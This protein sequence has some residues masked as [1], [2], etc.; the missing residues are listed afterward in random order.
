MT[1]PLVI[2]FDCKGEIPDRAVPRLR[3]ARRLAFGDQKVRL[4]QG[5]NGLGFGVPAPTPTIPFSSVI[6]FPK[7]QH[8]ISAAMKRHVGIFP[9]IPERTLFLDIE[10]HNAGREYE[11]PRNEFV[12]LGQ[13]AWGWDGGIVLTSDVD[14]ILD[15]IEAADLVIAHNGHT[16]DFSV[17][18]GDRAL[19]LTFEGRLF[20]TFVH[21]NMVFPPP[22]T[23][24]NRAGRKLIDTD[25]PKGAM[26][27]LGLDNL[28]FQLR[29]EGKIGSLADI[30][31]RYN[32]EG[33]SRADLDFGLIPL[34]DPEFREYAEQD[35]V[36]LRGVA[37]ELLNARPISEYDRR[38]Q[39]KAAINGQMSRNGIR[40]D[41]DAAKARVNEIE[42]RK[43]ELLAKLNEQYGFPIE[44]KMP[45]R[46]KAGKEAIFK[47][48]ADHGITKQTR[49]NWPLTDTGNLSLSGPALK[50]IT[51]GTDA[52]EL[53]T[54]LGILAGQRPLAQ[55]ALDYVRGDGRVHPSI[56]AVQRSGRC[57]VT[58]PG[59]T[60]WSARGPGAVEKQYFIPTEGHKMLEFDLSN[61]DQRIIAALSGDTAYA[62]RFDEGV[63]GHEINGRLMFG[64]KYDTDPA[65]YRNLAKA[66]GHALTYG[67]GAKRLAA[68]S[69]LDVETMYRFVDNFYDKYPLV[70][71]WTAK[72]RAQGE[73]YDQVT[74]A[75]GRD[76]IIDRY[77][78][79]ERGEWS[80]KAWTQAPALHGQSGTTEVCYDGLIRMYH[81][82]RRLLNWVICPIHDAILMDVPEDETEYVRKA[83]KECLETTIN[84]VHFPVSSGPDG[85]N[86]FAA[87][88]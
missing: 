67:A 65:Y 54:D 83:V 49:P 42:T 74:N 28:A 19:D 23:Y 14:E 34:D 6:R 35:I 39:V 5:P 12:R 2:E 36:A 61:A 59:M 45:W 9:D 66:P 62:A 44:G 53:G 37:R 60:T 47:I 63:D 8:Y 75:W 77:W 18:L 73:R 11:M 57:S 31:K 32:P 50:E 10:T 48:L 25:K 51:E 86:W 41:I 33:T 21:A 71:E 16:F 64:A 68:I 79:E 43:N 46:T 22:S 56:H 82:D 26:G 1:D 4:L 85:D 81:Y 72:V 40:L 88:H 69:G 78:N 70:A 58:E 7:G 13:Y 30:A 87:G 20:D 29:L 52:E 80:S 3:E 15:A 84:G 17:L 24:T 38:E 76:M 55:Q 27:W